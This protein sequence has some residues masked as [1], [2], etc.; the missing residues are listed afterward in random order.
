M[1]E[2][3]ET[4]KGKGLKPKTLRKSKIAGENLI[5]MFQG[6]REEVGRLTE[7]KDDDTLTEGDEE[8]PE[9][10]RKA[11]TLRAVHSL[12]TSAQTLL[13]DY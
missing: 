5:E 7:I 12:L 4:V 3:K 2:V 8:R 11:A 13:E 9:N 10:T 6:L 1:G